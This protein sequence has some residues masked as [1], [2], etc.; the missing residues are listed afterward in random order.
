MNL[1]FPLPNWRGKWSLPRAPFDS[2]Q[3]LGW[4]LDDIR[5]M[6]ELYELPD[7]ERNQLQVILE[8]IEQ[9]R[10]TLLQQRKVIELALSKFDE[11]EA[12]CQQQLVHYNGGGPNV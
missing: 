6:I 4:P 9:S 10:R 2:M 8:K 3:R 11:I 1:S 5:Q 12:R 7:G